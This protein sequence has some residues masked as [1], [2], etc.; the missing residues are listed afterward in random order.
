MGPQGPALSV[1]ATHLKW[2]GLKKGKSFSALIAM[3]P[4]WGGGG[5]GST[6]VAFAFLTRAALCTDFG[7]PNFVNEILSVVSQECC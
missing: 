2:L 5:E 4:A 6:E 7:N 3:T 1:S